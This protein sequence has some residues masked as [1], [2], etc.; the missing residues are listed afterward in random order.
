[1]R[2]RASIVTAIVF[3][4]VLLLFAIVPLLPAY[5]KALDL[6]KTQA[7]LVVAAYSAAVLVTSVPVGHWADR[8][9]PKRATVAGVVLMSASTL[10]FAAANSFWVLI[11]ARAGQGTSSAIA[12]SAGLAWLAAEAEPAERGRRL[13]TAMA[14][15]NLGALLGPLAAGPLGGAVG[16]RVPFVV[17]GAVAAV[18]AVLAA[19][20]A[21]PP[22]IH[23]VHPPLRRAFEMAVV[24]GP[25]AAA[26]VIMV[27][28]ACVSGTLDTLVPLGLGDHGYSP[29]AITAV[30]T[31]GGV[32]SVAANRVAGRAFDTIGGVP[33]ALFAMSCT[34]VGLLV[35]CGVVGA[36]AL[37][38]MFVVLAP[39]ITAQYAV[40]FPM[41]A[42]GA[43]RAGMG[44]AVSFGL[45]NLAWGAGFAVGP[46]V[47]AAIASAA[48]DRLA[49][50]LLAVLTVLVATRLRHLALPA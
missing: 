40:A 49:Y 7:G 10:A 2:P 32:I 21:S 3:L 43:D 13:G 5:Q 11:A 24:R 29:G 50:A 16:I 41:C 48:S 4:D 1:M 33:V 9:G 22:R 38:A 31:A 15:A 30:L 45:L 12:W 47:G 18:L 34:A 28:V 20:A 25:F 23:V 44:H 26:L 19:V 14:S 35:L 27:L 17:M 42:V 39:F 37:A 46:A 36:A 8:L 6:S